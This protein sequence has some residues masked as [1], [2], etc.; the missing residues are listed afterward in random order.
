MLLNE[1]N[2]LS[3]VVRVIQ[4]SLSQTKISFLS[5]LELLSVSSLS[6][7]WFGTA[8]T[9][10]TDMPNS[11]VFNGSFIPFLLHKFPVK[12]PYR[13]C[14]DLKAGISI[15]QTRFIKL[16]SITR[17]LTWEQCVMTHLFECP[18]GLTVLTFQYGFFIILFVFMFFVL[19]FFYSNCYHLR[20]LEFSTIWFTVTLHPPGLLSKCPYWGCYNYDI[21]L[22]LALICYYAKF[23]RWFPGTDF[24]VPVGRRMI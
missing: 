20:D 6:F 18:A 11:R 9:L 21:L 3:L 2:L 4:S 22:L 24:W 17:C 1:T 10:S 7:V 16:F 13:F 15:S 23:L 5:F 14:V 12:F 8:Q 19:G